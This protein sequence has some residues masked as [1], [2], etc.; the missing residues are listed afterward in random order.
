MSINE[1]TDEQWNNLKNK[2]KVHDY[3]YR[4]ICFYSDYYFFFEID[5]NIRSVVPKRYL[6]SKNKDITNDNDFL[7]KYYWLEIENFDDEQKRIRVNVKFN[8][9]LKEDAFNILSTRYKI[10][11]IIKS[12]PIKSINNNYALVELIPGFTCACYEKFND[13]SNLEVCKLLDV[14]IKFFNYDK[15]QIV[16]NFNEKIDK[17]TE[18]LNSIINNNI[19]KP[20]VLKENIYKLLSQY[21]DLNID[22]NNIENIFLNKYYEAANARMISFRRNCKEITFDSG[23][24]DNN[25]SIL[26]IGGHFDSK[27]KQY[28]LNFFG[29]SSSYS[30]NLLDFFAKIEWN[31][32]LPSLADLAL[33]GEKWG[34]NDTSY[35][36]LAG[37]LKLTF[38]KCVLD[39]QIFISESKNFAIFNT[40]LVDDYYHS[41]YGCFEPLHDEKSTQKWKLSYFCTKHSKLGQEMCK[42]CSVLPKPIKYIKN[43]EDILFNPDLKL[44]PN[45][46]HILEG[47]LERFP[48]DFIYKQCC[49]D[50]GFKFLYEKY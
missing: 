22:F 31:S 46:E 35:N 17:K 15:K 14:K 1:I 48:F 29:V 49:F 7:K 40:G 25:G 3:I 19:N 4:K 37:Y 24:R 5:F 42:H 43:N 33:K 2:Y 47:N 18:I 10:G 13:F 36:I 30:L 41:I 28:V 21:N 20:L 11:D 50:D 32:I 44:I 26:C 45:Q 34:F 27:D 16:V 6:Y 39:N 8:I 38:Y 12:V 9:F 23:Y